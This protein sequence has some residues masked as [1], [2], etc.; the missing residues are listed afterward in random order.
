M[1]GTA[2]QNENEWKWYEKIAFRFIFL[3]ILIHIAPWTWPAQI[4]FLDSLLGFTVEGYYILTDWLIQLVKTHIL[5]IETKV[6][7]NGSG[8][9]IDDWTWN[10]IAIF[11]AVSGSIIW[12]FADFRRRQYDT[13]YTWLQVLVRYHLALFMFVYGF[14]KIFPMQMP[15]PSLS[16][17]VTPIGE[18]T[19]M[20]LAWLFI[21]SS[22]FY[23]IFSGL[24]EAIGGALLL[25]RRTSSL[26]ALI[27]VGVLGNVVAL[28]L[29]YDVQVKLFSTMLLFMAVFLLIPNIRQF[30]S[31]F[32]LHNFVR[33]S[34]PDLNLKRR[35]QETTRVVLKVTF[36]AAFVVWP[37]YQSMT[38]YS[39]SLSGRN[40]EHSIAQGFFDVE[41]FKL[42]HNE[43]T[44]NVADT[45]RWENVVFEKWNE[46]S[47]KS[48]SESSTLLRYG[49]DYFAYDADID[50]EIIRIK[51]RK[52][53]TRN[54][55]F[56]YAK[57]DSS[58]ILLFGKKG[59]DSLHILLRQRSTEHFLLSNPLHWVQNSVK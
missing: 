28:N 14:I 18:F 48:G 39:K 36:I 26:G 21:G 7:P 58:R 22:T 38:N 12:T 5:H 19:S 49:R 52:D 32:I 23:Q 56:H 41:E 44:Q 20:R 16:Q 40:T 34:F 29:F 27:L 15:P 2:P 53:S 51:F 1:I 37:F 8:D 47:I 35:W 13:L 10:G 46:G 3:L 4:P 43:I 50:K 54:Y 9:T 45:I 6:V 31:F 57:P 42:N 17:M 30:W 25:S 59:N 24:C 11:I 55:V 33:L